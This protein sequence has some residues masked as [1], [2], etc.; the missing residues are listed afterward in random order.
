MTPLSVVLA[1]FPSFMMLLI[2]AST[3][4]F[5]LFPSLLGFLLIPIVI[6]LFPLACY[7]LH[8]KLFPLK[9]GVSN[10]YAQEYSAWWGTHQIQWIFIAFPFLEAALR[11]VPGLFSCWLRAWGSKV[12]KQVYWTAKLEVADR[13][14]LEIGD[15][16]IFGFQCG[17]Y[18]H[19]VTPRRN[20][21][22]LVLERIR[23]DSHAFLGGDSVLGPGAWIAE[24]VSL[25]AGARI[26]PREHVTK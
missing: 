19:V 10:L 9:Q 20:R 22:T 24:G 7:H 18:P 11:G 16:V 3:L 15:R 2:A 4:R 1:F 26:R 12:G 21:L 25:P 17:L 14:L 8:C 5:L 6:Y 23:I 13:G